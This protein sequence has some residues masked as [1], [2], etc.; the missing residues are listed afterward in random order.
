[1][2]HSM[3]PSTTLAPPTLDELCKHTPLPRSKHGA[4]GQL[5]PSATALWIHREEC[6]QASSYTAR[7]GQGEIMM[8]VEIALD[9]EKKA[10]AK[11]GRD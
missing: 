5:G 7:A 8:R 10:A 3:T 9:H 2:A 4:E 11:N 6:L 1:M